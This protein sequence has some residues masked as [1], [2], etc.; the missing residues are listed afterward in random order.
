[1]PAILISI[2]ILTVLGLAFGLGLAVASRAFHVETDPRIK[3]VSDVLPGVNCGACGHPGCDGYAAA[4]VQGEKPDLCA[5]GGPEVAAA[6]AMVMGLEVGSGREPMVAFVR[7][8]GDREASPPRFMYDGIPDCRAAQL[9]M[10]GPKTCEFGCLGFGSCVAACPFDAISMSE[11]GLPIINRE[12]CVGC[13]VCVR[14]C[15][16]GVI[17]LIPAHAAVGLACNNPQ[18]GKLVKGVCEYVCIKCRKCVKVS[19]E[20]V[21][22]MG[23]TM[24]RLCYENE[25]AD[26]TAAIEACPKHCFVTLLARG[27]ARSAPEKVEAG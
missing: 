25:G 11:E 9:V 16:R 23:E 1:M 13:G 20:G 22:E 24:P 27:V 17:E 7:C 2:A 12:R 4:V 10:G 5:P 15:P 26:F 18:K 3:D 19:E 21:I 14:V 8:Q 6:V